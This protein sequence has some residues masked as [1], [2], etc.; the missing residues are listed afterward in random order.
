[1]PWVRFGMFFCFCL[2]QINSRLQRIRTILALVPTENALS[3]NEESSASEDEVIRYHND[4]TENDVT[5]YS[6][7]P[8][9]YPSS[10]DK[11][12]I[13]SNDEDYHPNTDLFNE[14]TIP[15]TPIINE[16]FHANQP[17]EELPLLNSVSS[18]L[19]PLNSHNKSLTST[20]RASIKRKSNNV[21]KYV[22][23]RTKKKYKDT[24]KLQI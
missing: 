20:T 9:S 12:H 3:S 2:L 8:K 14:D 17:P 10:L 16:M 13:F 21:P 15:A 7:E 24:H 19:S 11:L 5:Y 4:D 1:M 18:V 22:T 23:K 6:S